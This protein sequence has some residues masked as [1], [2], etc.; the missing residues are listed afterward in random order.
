MGNVSESGHDGFRGYQ[1]ALLSSRSVSVS[2][3]Q[4]LRPLRKDP[5]RIRGIA[6][7]ERARHSEMPDWQFGGRA[8]NL[9]FYPTLAHEPFHQCFHGNTLPPRFI[10]EAGFGFV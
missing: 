1:N 9:G 5:L 4:H 7:V 2:Y 3:S 10:G 8:G 6:P